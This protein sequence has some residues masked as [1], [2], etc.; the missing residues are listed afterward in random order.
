MFLCAIR[1][2]LPLF[3]ISL[4]FS[5][6]DSTAQLKTELSEIV[7]LEKE[8]LPKEMNPTEMVLFS[9]KVDS[10]GKINVIDVNYSNE[11]IK[12]ILLSKL[13]KAV[14]KNEFISTKIH[15]YKV[16]FKKL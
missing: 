3:S 10:L 7:T 5:Q 11:N 15:Y 6:S 13:E 12:K 1:A 9:F 16:L 2:R 4:G 8:K 14:L